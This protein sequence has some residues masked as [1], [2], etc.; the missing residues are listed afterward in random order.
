MPSAAYQIGPDYH[1]AKDGFLT[2]H[3][4]ESGVG[5][6]IFLGLPPN[7][8]LAG[9]GVFNN[10]R[11]MLSAPAKLLFCRF[12]L[13]ERH[14]NPAKE[15]DEQ[16]PIEWGFFPCGGFAPELKHVVTRAR[17]GFCVVVTRAR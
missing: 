12:V 4:D 8:K 11:P 5:I 16:E 14:P 7:E 1:L 9:A 13:L 2:G 17:R 3:N 10:V 6:E 15:H